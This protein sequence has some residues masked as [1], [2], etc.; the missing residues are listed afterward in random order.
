LYNLQTVRGCIHNGILDIN[1]SMSGPHQYYGYLNPTC[2]HTVDLRNSQPIFKQYRYPNSSILTDMI[3]SPYKLAIPPKYI[4]QCPNCKWIKGTDIS[5][6]D[7]IKYN[8]S[9]AINDH[10]YV[11][12]NNKTSSDSLFSYPGVLELNEHQLH[13]PLIKK[14]QIYNLSK[15]RVQIVRN[16]IPFAFNQKYVKKYEHAKHRLRVINYIYGHNYVNDYLMKGNG[17]FIEQHEF[18]QSITPANNQCGGFVILGHWNNAITLELIAIKIPYNYTLLINAMAIH[19]DSGLVGNYIMSMTGNHVAMGTADTVYLKNK[20]TANNVSVLT[21]SSN[22]INEVK[23]IDKT[24]DNIL[25]TSNKMKLCDLHHND[26]IIKKRIVNDVNN[27]PSLNVIQKYIWQPV[28][29]T[30]NTSY[31][32]TKTIGS[33]LPTI[34]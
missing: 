21:Q 2:H 30:P 20:C 24:F 15:F 13:I 11:N 28:I 10:S 14:P 1:T 5:K 12:V 4:L 19:G 16:D 31:G 23:S 32:W 33:Y 22:I 34:K 6:H 8:V 18:I 26:H 3:E 27:D 7:I 29:L 17:M 9:T 25:I